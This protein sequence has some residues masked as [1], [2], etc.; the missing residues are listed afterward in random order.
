MDA[1]LDL[2]ARGLVLPVIT[3]APLHQL[4]DLV[5]RVV[6]G[7]ILGKAVVKLAD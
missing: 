6:E 3:T 5:D 4:N 1:V 7:R 2:T